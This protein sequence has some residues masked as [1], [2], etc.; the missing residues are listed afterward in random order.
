M[1]TLTAGGGGSLRTVSL[2]GGERPSLIQR[3]LRELPKAHLHL[4]FEGAMRHSTLSEL[5]AKYNVPLPA[6]LLRGTLGPG[7]TYADFDQFT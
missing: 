6:M 2:G 4:H 5:C 7:E 1:H 3:C